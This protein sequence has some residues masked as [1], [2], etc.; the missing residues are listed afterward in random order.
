[1]HILFVHQSFPAQFGHIARHL[2]NELGHQC[3]FVSETAAGRVAGIDKIQYKTAGG[4]T[5]H[6]HFCS[7]TFENAIWHS[8]SVYSAL[9]DRPDVRPDLIVGHSG[10]GSTIF[11]PELY[12]DVPI[13]NFFEYYY[14]P[15]DIQSDMDFRQDLGWR[16]T[17]LGFMR[18]R[19]RNAMILLDLQNCRYGY[20]PTQFQKSRFPA[21]YTSKLR[22]IFDGVDRSIYHSF[23]DSLRPLMKHRKNRLIH[24]VEIGPATR[25]VTY[26]SRGFESMRGFDQFMRSATLIAERFPDVAFFVVGEDRV[27]YGGDLN[28]TGGKSF[29]QWVLERE[30]FDLS[31]FHFLGRI[32]PQSLARLLAASDLHLY[33]TAPFVLSWSMM[34]AMSC[35]A[36]VLGSSTAPVMDVIVDGENGL[37]ADFFSPEQFA[38]KA[39]EVLE[40]P[41]AARRLGLAA[42]QM[43]VD[44]YSLES[45]LPQMLELYTDATED[46]LKV[47][48]ACNVNLP[49]QQELG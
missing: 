22:V 42:E 7:R 39:V 47:P 2:V 5:K 19:S 37:L 17:P 33:F 14:L 9:A 46:G 35:G 26:C 28:H 12:P 25:V 34:N 4:A 11:L 27:A 49:I 18:A 43:I 13:I 36:V 3:T 32:E 30:P 1:M 20:T 29:K 6:S 15:H 21:E 40:N 48:P 24:G 45:V 38:S 31:K 16:E 41:D 8:H 23:D 44:Q 10:F